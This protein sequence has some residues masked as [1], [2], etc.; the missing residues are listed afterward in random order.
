MPQLATKPLSWFKANPQV[1]KAF[2]DAELRALGESLR[3]RQLQPV[4][5]KPDGTLIAGE[6]RYRAAK[7]VGL[8]SLQVIITD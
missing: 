2:D 5:A 1:R 8:E 3:V 4:L 6:R 7:L